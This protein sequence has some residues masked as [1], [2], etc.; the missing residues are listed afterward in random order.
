MPGVRSPR[1]ATSRTILRARVIREARL[2]AA[3]FFPEFRRPFVL[4][5]I[6]WGAEAWADLRRD[7]KLA[8]EKADR[9]WPASWEA[10]DEEMARLA[11]GTAG[12]SPG[13]REA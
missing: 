4:E 11:S 13:P 2:D 12:D 8:P 10:F 9:A 7:Y 3:A 6:L 5:D 1:W